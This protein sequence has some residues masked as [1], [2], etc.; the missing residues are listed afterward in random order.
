MVVAGKRHT[1]C[2]IGQ[3]DVIRIRGRLLYHA[4]NFIDGRATSRAP[5]IQRAKQDRDQRNRGERNSENAKALTHRDG[6]LSVI[7]AGADAA[8]RAVPMG[9]G[10][11][12]L[13]V[14]LTAVALISIL[15]GPLYKRSTTRRTTID[16]VARMVE[17]SATNADYI[18]LTDWTH[19]VTF[20]RYYHG[21]TPWQTLPPLPADAH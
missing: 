17:Q 10:F 9:Q 13:G 8:Q 11:R 20:S 21:S 14:A 4:R 6:T 7:A 2:P 15:F 16:E 1:M 3:H 19:G 18:V 5:L 12:V